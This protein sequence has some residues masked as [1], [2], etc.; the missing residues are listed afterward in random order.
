MS[1]GARREQILEAAATLFAS[2]GLRASMKDIADACG[3]LPGSLYHHFPSKESIVIELVRRYQDDLD[4]IAA[5]ALAKL[6]APDARPLLDRVVELGSEIAGCAAR[7]P[8]ALLATLYE[9]PS[10]AGEE[11]RQLAD[12]TPDSIHDAMLGLLEA[13][14]SAREVRARVDLSS[15]STRLCQSMLRHGITNAYLGPGARRPPELRCRL[16]LEGIAAQVPTRAALDRS[17]ALAAARAAVARWSELDADTDE[18]DALLR[19]AARE[20][21]GRRGYDATTLRE[22]AEVSGLSTGTVYR[23]YPSK[24]ELLDAVM[25]AYTAKRQ[26][27]WDAVMG[28][29]STPLEKVDA[30][31]WLYIRLSERFGAEYQL[32]M[33]VVRQS[34][35]EMGSVVRPG[36][37]SDV[38][39]LLAEGVASGELRLV[40]GTTSAYSR[41]VYEALWTP[42]DVVDGIGARAAHALARD[43]VLAGALV[44]R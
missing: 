19:A 10:G 23:L 44:R 11:L 34:P 2:G 40:G 24:A 16:V 36:R 18:R 5:G 30:L 35:K 9:A 37:W 8:G 7:H 25:G 41:C 13:G 28:S 33:G 29:G 20:E 1:R 26:L 3:M 22:I 6:D 21:F 31:T 38:E 15:L 4:A 43:T 32:Q 17:A 14:R 12:R 42:Q 39:V 27:A